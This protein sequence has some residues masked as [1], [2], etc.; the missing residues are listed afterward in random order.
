MDYK[1][2]QLLPLAA[3][4]ADRYTSKESTSVTYETAGAL[5]EAVLYYMKECE[6]EG[7]AVIRQGSMPGVREIYR[8][9][10]GLVIEKARRARVLHDAII[11]DFEDYGCMNYRDTIQKGMPGFFLHY[12]PVF[13]PG[14]HILS[15][16]YPLL[17]GNPPLCGVDLIF[18]YLK[19]IWTEMQFL[20]RFHPDM[21]RRLLSQVS[22]EYKEL[23]LD[24]LCDPV[25]FH[26]VGCMLSKQAPGDPVPPQ[27]HPG[28]IHAVFSRA[29]REE[30]T[31]RVISAIH[32][33]IHPYPAGYFG[34]AAPGYAARIKN[35]ID[36][37]CLDTVF[38]MDLPVIPASSGPEAP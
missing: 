35:G 26:V 33:A 23:Y 34:K 27:P 30:I 16:D 37:N 13:A 1:I 38:F 11:R 22:P 9:G 12:D 7:N 36:N 8:R 28:R 15:L 14:R 24:N 32:E 4:L 6:D 21:V 10:A 19:G 29:D 2:E 18:E 25:L 17:C 31:A 3:E 20:N 5:M